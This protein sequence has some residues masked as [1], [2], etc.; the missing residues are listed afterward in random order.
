MSQARHFVLPAALAFAAIS[1]TVSAE[2]LRSAPIQIYQQRMPD[3]RIVLT[4]R[5]ISSAKT[6]RTWELAHEDAAGARLRSEQ[7]RLE[8]QAVSERIQRRIDYQQQRSDEMDALYSRLQQAQRDV[9]A[10]RQTGWAIYPQGTDE[11]FGNR[12]PGASMPPIGATP[13]VGSMPPIG[14]TPP[15]GSPPPRVWP[16]PPRMRPHGSGP[17]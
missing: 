17:A 10:A 15:I 14:A 5:P 12:P 1:A 4:D 7:V 13:P 11:R 6:E 2:E 9:E 16:T 3:G 8:A